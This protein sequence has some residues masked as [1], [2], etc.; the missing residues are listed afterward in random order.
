[1]KTI[2]VTIETRFSNAVAFMLFKVDKLTTYLRL[3]YV[4]VIC[5]H[6]HGR[7][8]YTQNYINT[9]LITV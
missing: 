4:Q 1:M 3:F 8:N 2:E 5:N 7:E 9:V 6:P